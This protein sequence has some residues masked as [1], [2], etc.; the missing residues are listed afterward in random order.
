MA[1]SKADLDFERRH[2]WHPYAGVGDDAETAWPVAR[3]E[4]LHLIL[5]DG[6]RL[7]DGMASWWSMIHGYN[8]PRLN[9]AAVDQLQ[10]MPH[11]MFG[12]LTHDGA[13]QLA[14][15]LLRIVPAGLD[16]VF[17]SDSGSVAVEIAIKMAMQHRQA[18]GEGRRNRLLAL[19]GGYHGDT[20]G[21]MALC[22][23]EAGMHKNFGD[24]MPAHVFAPR[25]RPR[26]G[27]PCAAEDTAELEKSL[28]QNRD[29]LCAVILEPILQGAGGMRDYSADYL[30]RVRELCDR[31]DLL[32]IADEIATGFGR[33]GAMFACEHAGVSPDILCLGK[34]LTGGHMSMAATLCSAEVAET[35][36]ADG[37][38]LMHGPTFMANPLACA[39][40]VASIDM[41]LEGDWRSR[42]AAIER[43]FRSGLA[44]AAALPGVAEVRCL[45]ASATIE[46]RKPFAAAP[47]QRIL[48]E[49]GVWLRP[50]G[51]LLYA[52]PP[53]VLD[54][55]SQRQ[56]CE[57][58]L[59]A[60]RA[61]P[62]L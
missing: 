17:F 5:D 29:R 52:M 33:T 51:A 12:G 49:R 42:V 43:G 3:T 7:I 16:K 48:A 27:Q 61:I 1:P 22:D 59:E 25:P 46:M 13:I 57:A 20:F 60:A 55:D 45:G 8:H 10:R 47:A 36:S 24:A 39:C 44:D 19:R 2:L 35:I 14:R 26:F 31:H 50:F 58:M 23:P 32:L 28:E 6:R 41:L 62:S 9:E 11:V 15:R 56:L 18:A 53:Y 38:R 34:A 54:E 21:A 37:G 40:A 30:R 4:G